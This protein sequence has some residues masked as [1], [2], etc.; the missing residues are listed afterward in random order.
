MRFDLGFN[1][2]IYF[3][4][5]FSVQSRL[6]VYLF[7]GTNNQPLPPLLFRRGIQFGNEEKLMSQD[8]SIGSQQLCYR[9]FPP[10]NLS[11]SSRTKKWKRRGRSGA[12]LQ[13]K[14]LFCR[15]KW[16]KKEWKVS[17]CVYNREERLIKAVINSWIQLTLDKSDRLLFGYKFTFVYYLHQQTKKKTATIYSS[18]SPHYPKSMYQLNFFSPFYYLLSLSLSFIFCLLKEEIEQS[19]MCSFPVLL[20]ERVVVSLC[21]SFYCVHNESIVWMYSCST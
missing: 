2:I 10:L 8:A 11:H 20:S 13:E 21:F 19:N 18:K 17:E 9:T 7:S 1:S 14:N 6:L 12:S 15:E 5:F 4:T 3:N 16:K